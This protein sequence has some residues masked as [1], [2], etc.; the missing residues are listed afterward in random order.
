[1]KRNDDKEISKLIKEELKEIIRIVKKQI[2]FLTFFFFFLVSMLVVIFGLSKI[3]SIIIITSSFFILGSIA[4]LSDKFK[5]AKKYKFKP[6]KRF[7][8]KNELGD[9]YID[10]SQIHQAIIYLSLVE[11]EIW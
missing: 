2:V 11:D 4:F 8:Q 9:I 10:E 6:K 7:T 1:M 3:V 5:R